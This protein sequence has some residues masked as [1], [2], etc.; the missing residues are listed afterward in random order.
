MSQFILLI[1]LL[2]VSTFVQGQSFRAIAF[3][4][5]GNDEAHKS[6]VREAIPWFTDKSRMLGFSFHATSNWDSLNADVLANTDIVIFLD[7]RPEKE[8]Q[9]WAFQQ[10]MQNGGA[11]M[12]FHFAAFA[13]NGSAYPQNWNWYHIHFL[14]AG[15]YV[16]NTWRPTSANLRIHSRSHPATKGIPSTIRS[17]PNEWYRWQIDLRKNPNIRILASIDPSSFPLGTGPK[18]D[19]IWHE[20]FY[21]VVWTNTKYRMIYF[22]MGHNDIDYENKTNAGLSHSFGYDWQDWMILQSLSWLGRGKRDKQKEH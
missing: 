3:Y 15:E 4:G 10:F 11:W 2:F 21:P 8:E 14:G 9:R 16:S 12:G 22:N 17:S 6:F 20:G 18:P 7:G 19:E 13:M 1:S 5:Q